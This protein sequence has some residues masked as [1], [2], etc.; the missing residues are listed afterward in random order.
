MSLPD[1][2]EQTATPR[3]SII[4]PAY[5]VAGYLERALDSALAQTM[6]N[7]EVIVVD[8]GSSD[9]TY[10]VACRIAAR[11]PRVRVLRNERNI[12]LAATRNRAFSVAR[13]EWIALL[14]GDDAWLPSRLEKMLSASGDAEVVSDDIYIVRRSSTKPDEYILRSLLQEQRVWLIKPCQLSLLDFARHD[15]GLVKPIIRRSFL[16]EHRLA[17]DPTLPVEDFS[18]SFEIL[19]LGA[20]WL[21]LPLGYYLYTS[22]RESAICADYRALWQGTIDTTKILLNHPAVAGD[23]ALAAALGQ[24]IKNARGILG[25]NTF[26][27]MLRQRRFTEIAHLLLEQPSDIASTAKF[28]TRRLHLRLTRK[29][30]L[31]YSTED[32]HKIDKAVTALSVSI[33][34]PTTM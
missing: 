23:P 13:S 9:A 18:F 30:V 24:R 8:D 28:I 32:L 2:R 7:F 29:P 6:P 25:F 34:K 15:L 19:A 21:Q 1:T 31:T 12:G 4:V 3:V 14:D 5:N 17:Y 10:E 16:I 27:D 22:D 20:R 26:R 11:D 33:R